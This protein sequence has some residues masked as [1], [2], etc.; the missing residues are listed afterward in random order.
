MKVET[1]WMHALLTPEQPIPDG[2]KAWNGSDPEARFAVYRNNVTASLID[3]LA[4]TYSV[5]QQLV[6]EDFFRAMARQ[7]VHQSPPRSAM[8]TEYGAEFPDFVAAFAP[9]R[10]LPYLADLAAL[11]QLYVQAY[12]AAD[13]EPI[14]AEQLQSLLADP[15]ALADC[16]LMLHPSLRL[17]RSDYAV[18]SLWAAHQD[19][20][21]LSGIDIHKFESAWILRSGLQVAVFNMGRGDFHFAR[22]LR[23]GAPF[24]QAVDAALQQD[25]DFDLQAC[26]ALMLREQLITGIDTQ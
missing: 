14:T 20:G 26:L 2:L 13:A 4:E 5:T 16:R 24:A 15:D 6:G 21:D 10:Q 1:S 9:V 19:E 22:A 23:R 3:A 25:P 17:H 12:H 11:E 18:V 7:Y 8:L